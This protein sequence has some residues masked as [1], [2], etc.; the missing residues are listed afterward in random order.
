M[1]TRILWLDGVRA[2]AIVLVVLLHTVAPY[3]YQ[4]TQIPD[5]HWDVANIIDSFT[6]IC[7]PL[8]FM[9]SG[10]LFFGER[11]PKLR[12]HLRILI[13]LAFY[14]LL[15]LIYIRLYQGR[16]IWPLMQSIWAEPIMYHLWF[17]YSLFLVYLVAGLVSTRILGPRTALIFAVLCFVL[18]NPRLSHLTQ[19]FGLR[20]DSLF[21]FDGNIIYY[22]LYAVLGSVFGHIE[23]RKNKAIVLV[24]PFLYI[25]SSLLIALLTHLA[26]FG[27]DKYIERFHDYNS[28]LVF[29]GSLSIFTFFKAIEPGLKILETPIRILAKYSLPI[30]GVHVILIDFFKLE[31]FRDYDQPYLDISLTFL[32][33]LGFSLLLAIVIKKLDRHGWVS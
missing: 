16:E 2:C 3:I 26:S 15:A 6:R 29:V 4:L 24:M 12:N 17:F 5:L 20:L 30:Y 13:A 32:A 9:I 31:G 7:V 1:K 21:Q 23:F 22:I 11:K 28:I 19:P 18:L 8:F 33:A 10:F 25:G 27:A 14:S